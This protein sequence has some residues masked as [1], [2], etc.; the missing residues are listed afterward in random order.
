MSK[1]TGVAHVVFFPVVDEELEALEAQGKESIP[2]YENTLL[3]VKVSHS[4]PY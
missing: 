1:E 4:E 2:H 3:Q